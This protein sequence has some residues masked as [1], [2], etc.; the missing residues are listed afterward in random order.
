MKKILLLTAVAAMT[1]LGV[2]GCIEDDKYVFYQ[3]IYNLHGERTDAAIEYDK[4]VALPAK[5]F[6]TELQTLFAKYPEVIKGFPK[7][8]YRSGYFFKLEGLACASGERVGDLCNHAA[9][10]VL[11]GQ[12]TEAEQKA[13]AF[14]IATL[15]NELKNVDALNL[16]KELRKKAVPGGAVQ[17]VRR[18]YDEENSEFL[19]EYTEVFA[20]K[21]GDRM[22]PRYGLS[23]TYYE[24][25]MMRSEIYY[26]ANAPVGYAFTFSADGYVTGIYYY[27]GKGNREQLYSR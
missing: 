11:N 5:G 4:G 15:L 25:G 20:G 24:N 16:L 14:R 1:A 6:K 27:D 10:F 7:D 12:F 26:K 9:W 23:R 2:T 19:K 13:Y 18:F 17:V 3:Q 21:I 8:K 22:N